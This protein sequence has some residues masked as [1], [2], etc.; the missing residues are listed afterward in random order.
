MYKYTCAHEL[1][2]MLKNMLTNFMLAN[3]FTTYFFGLVALHH[4]AKQR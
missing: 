3:D 1:L 2:N 4:Y